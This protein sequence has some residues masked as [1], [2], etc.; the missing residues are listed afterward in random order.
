[1][2]ISRI[3]VRYPSVSAPGATT[4]ESREYCFV[5]QALIKSGGMAGD[6]HG[7]KKESLYYDTNLVVLLVPAR[8]MAGWPSVR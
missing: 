8:P 6:G 2:K 3:R 5:D 1:M 7:A 4:A